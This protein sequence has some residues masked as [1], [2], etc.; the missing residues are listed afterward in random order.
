ML[1]RAF[2]VLVL[3]AG[4]ALAIELDLPVACTPGQDC[5]I[6]QYVDRDAGPGVRDY[7]CG[8]ETYDGHDGTDIRLRTTED[9]KKGVAVLAVAPGKVL[10]LRDGE[11]DRL[12]RSEEDRAK[13]AD[14]ECGNGVRIDHGD[15]WVTQYCHLRQGSVTAKEGETVE[16]GA[17]LGEIGYSGEAAFP[18]VHLAVSKDDETVDPFLTEPDPACGKE[19]QSLWSAKAKAALPYQAGTLL[20][21]G[22]SDQPIELEALE[23]GAPLAQPTPDTPVVTYMWAIN[24]QKDDVIALKLMRGDEVLVDNSET[25]DRNK[26]QMMLFAGKKAPQGGWPKGSYTGTVMVT[27]GGKPVISETTPPLVFD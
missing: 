11:P 8:A 24:L 22:M 25:L 10:G 14:R 5:F 2:G 6:Q 13:V 7:S 9:V 27:R 26:A 18:H 16:A 15:G 21:L 20:G 17:K 23:T 1:I 19:G 12:I 4:P 3:T